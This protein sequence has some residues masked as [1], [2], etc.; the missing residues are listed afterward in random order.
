[1]WHIESAIVVL[2]SLVIYSHSQGFHKMSIKTSAKQRLL[3]AIRQVVSRF[4]RLVM[5]CD[6]YSL[7]VL[8]SCCSVSDVLD[9]GVDLVEMLSRKRQPLKSKIA[10]YFLSDE[11]SSIDCFLHDF[12][13]GKEMYKS[14][15]LMFNYHLPD[16]VPLRQIAD[17]VDIAK[18]LGCVE[19]F[20]NFVACESHLFH[21]CDFNL[22][23]IYPT[24]EATVAKRIVSRVASAV[25]TLGMNP[26]IR[27]QSC[28]HQVPAMVATG[29]FNLLKQTSPLSTEKPRDIVVILCRCLD[30]NVLFI[31]EYTYQAFVYD[32]LH[33]PCAT[34]PRLGIEEDDIWEYKL[35]SSTGKQEKRKALLNTE[36]DM[37]WNDY[38]YLHIQQVNAQVIKDVNELSTKLGSKKSKGSQGH[39]VAETF[40]LVRGFPML[41]LKLEKCWAHVNISERCFE[42]VESLKLLTIGAMEQALATNFEKQGK[43][44]H[45]S[46]I[47]QQL[48]T[49]VG[50]S[51]IPEEQRLRLVLL[52]LHVYRNVGLEER[53]T[54]IEAANLN[55]YSRSTIQDILQLSLNAGIPIGA[56]KKEASPKTAHRLDIKCD[57]ASHY[58]KHYGESEYD[59]SQFYPEIAHLV[60]R[61]EHDKLPEEDFPKVETAK[62]PT[63]GGGRF[64]EEIEAWDLGIEDTR[65]ESRP[66]L[67]LYILGGVGFAE[68]RQVATL[69]ESSAYQIYLGG[70]TIHVP[71]NLISRC[72]QKMQDTL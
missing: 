66:K 46:K 19:L 33:I 13:P 25:S 39:D 27:Y 55:K 62:S 12:I 2:H 22:F 16:D 8:S 61:I 67:L 32:V 57:A 64:V 71:S 21:G 20:L 15:F 40:Q 11:K 6:A 63:S 52:F 23:D 26:E 69:V 1:M 5:I 68:M 41:Q 3:W 45:H 58:K 43:H 7:R 60:Q 24:C 36:A 50:D 44:A 51:T 42:M 72:K 29:L 65:S 48:T 37:L 34:D 70:D 38:R 35:V 47:S 59:L 30:P 4:G 17:N 14:A 56:S 18:V 28:S 53:M 54:L 49:L 10:L 9:E 31:H